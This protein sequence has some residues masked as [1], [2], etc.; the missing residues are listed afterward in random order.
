MYIQT[1]NRFSPL[2][3]ILQIYLVGEI[4]HVFRSGYPQPADLFMVLGILGAGIVFFTQT[5][6]KLSNI[7]LSGLLFA[8]YT[9]VVNIVNYLFIPDPEFLL[10]SLYYV[11]NVLSLFFI[12]FLANRN[13]ETLQHKFY[14]ALMAAFV[15]QLIVGFLLFQGGSLRAIGTFNNP[16]QFSYWV[17]LSFCILVCL[18]YPARL[19]YLDCAAACL[20]TWFVLA[21]LSKAALLSFALV[22]I[23]VLCSRLVSPFM[24]YIIG[25]AILCGFSFILFDLQGFSQKL[26]E[27][28]KIENIYER[29]TSVGEQADDTIEARGYYR[30]FQNPEYLLLGS[31]EGGYERFETPYQLHSG[32]GTIIFSYGIL[33]TTAFALLLFMIFRH[34]PPIFWVMLAAVMFYGLTHHNIRFTYFWVFLG[35]CYLASVRL[36]VLRDNANHNAA[37]V[38]VLPHHLQW[39]M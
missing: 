37:A 18:R 22:V 21:G 29:F 31:G 24:R 28:Q 13:H 35:A 15:L 14:W 34:L 6:A 9:F 26:F 7:A 1:Y 17:L 27:L 11:F 12:I 30:L 10:S 38:P 5:Q 39:A 19:T 33:G 32:I 3:L 8:A 4:F 23:G 16:N 25:F 2:L 20:L 36:R